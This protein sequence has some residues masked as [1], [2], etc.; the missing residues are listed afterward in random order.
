MPQTLDHRFVWPQENCLGIMVLKNPNKFHDMNMSFYD[1]YFH[2]H[3]ESCN[4]KHD[5]QRGGVIF[6]SISVG[7][8][9]AHVSLIPLNT[10]KIVRESMMV[11]P[12]QEWIL[13]TSQERWSFHMMIVALNN[14]NHVGIRTRR[15][16]LTTS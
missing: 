12:P 2:T 15:K 1:S 14:L 5:K 8:R 9:P 3:N 4:P 16:N 7:S 6:G 13:R 10:M 11:M